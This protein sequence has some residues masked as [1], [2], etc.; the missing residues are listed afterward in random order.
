MKP[1]LLI[2]FVLY[3]IVGSAQSRTQEYSDFEI[4]FTSLK[5]KLIFIDVINNTKGF[6][7]DALIIIGDYVEIE[8]NLRSCESWTSHL[9]R[10]YVLNK[11]D[12][13]DEFDDTTI[14]ESFLKIFSDQKLDDSNVYFIHLKNEF[15]N[16]EIDINN[17]KIRHV[18]QETEAD[19][20]ETMKKIN[21]Q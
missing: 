13:S 5:G 8:K 10:T 16:G 19:L 7:P 11:K 20:C 9:N 2:T 18:I 12:Y 14:M 6:I 21:W 4:Y 15:E 17:K 1:L 3:C